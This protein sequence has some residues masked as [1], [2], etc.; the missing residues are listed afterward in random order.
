[1]IIRDPGQIA[2]NSR[3]DP[4]LGS[5]KWSQGARYHLVWPF[6]VQP[7]SLRRNVEGRGHI[8]TAHRDCQGT[9][10]NSRRSHGSR[11]P[12]CTPLKA[13]KMS[14]TLLPLRIA[15]S[16]PSS[17]SLGKVTSLSVTERFLILGRGSMAKS[18]SP[19]PQPLN[20]QVPG[21]RAWLEG[22]GHW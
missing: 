6:G 7:R 5:E 4:L 16:C 12:S 19:H 22:V 9:L 17:R 10:V 8:D 1:M 18:D 3:I 2:V 11:T 15:H 13:P 14:R 20:A 21:G